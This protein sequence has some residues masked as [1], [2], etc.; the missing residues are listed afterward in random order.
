MFGLGFLEI[1]AAALGADTPG[2]TAKVIMAVFVVPLLLSCMSL[3]LL[4]NSA[5]G[6]KKTCHISL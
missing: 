6:V 3:Y 2:L 5:N 4:R 1:P